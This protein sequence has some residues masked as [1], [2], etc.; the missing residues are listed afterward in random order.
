[1]QKKQ[2]FLNDKKTE[3]Y[4]YTEGFAKM[5]KIY[6]KSRENP[7]NFGKIPSLFLELKLTS[8]MARLY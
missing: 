3:T 1:M 6:R 4:P 8:R 2:S 7:E 5:P